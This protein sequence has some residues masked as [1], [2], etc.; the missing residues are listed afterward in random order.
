M[1]LSTDGIPPTFDIGK[2]FRRRL[3]HQAYRGQDQGGISTPAD[4]PL[5]MLF[6]GDTGEQYG[7]RD[8]WLPD[9]S[10]RYT[11]EG[12]VGDMKMVRGNVAIRDHAVNGKDIYLFEKTS[13][14]FIQYVGQMVCGGYEWIANI[15]DREGNL[16]TII[17]FYLRPLDSVTQWNAGTTNDAEDE[18]EEDSNAERD[19]W[20]LPIDQLREQA[21]AAPLENVQ[22]SQVHRNVYKRSAAVRTYVLRR[23]AGI[24]EGCDSQAPFVAL[25][26]YPYLEPH[27]TRRLSDGG[28]DHPAH[29]IAL[30]PN[31]HRRAHHAVDSTSFNHQLIS[32]M[33][34]IEVITRH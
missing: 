4:H 33:S 19:A 15:P 10:F 5:I 25:H 34:T 17:V 23:A 28:P 9:G 7:Y 3:L 1:N 20:A 6:T 29:V 13:K 11:G 18:D 22:S 8:E 32:K 30:C 16:R 26:G 12:Q 31:C 21:L 2:P 27:H 24:C 14:A